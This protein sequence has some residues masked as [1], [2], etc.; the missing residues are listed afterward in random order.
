[1]TD[2]E[3]MLFYAGYGNVLIML[4]LVV[5]LYS[6][7]ILDAPLAFGFWL[8]TT[9]L[10]L[11]GLGSVRTE[12]AP[13]GSGTLIGSGIFFAVI[14]I[15]VLGIFMDIINPGV[16]FALLILVVGIGVMA[17]GIRRGKRGR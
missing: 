9:A 16:A 5:M 8:L 11:I 14:S 1:M 3:D 6:M 15:S 10:I 13:H 2:K 17:M 7:D 12:S 4:G